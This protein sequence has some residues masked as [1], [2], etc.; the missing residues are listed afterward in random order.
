[1]R[2]F[3][4]FY[5]SSV[6]KKLIVG[7]TGL[8]LISYL[9]IH[10]FGNL[11]IFRADGGEAFDTYAEVLPQI[12]VIRI[13]EIG[14]FLLFI[15]HIIT[16]AY[17]WI[18]NKAARGDAYKIQKK[19]ETSKVTSR[20]MFLT[21]SIVFIFLVVH[22]R[23]FWFNSRYEATEGY[24][25]FE[26][27]RATFSNPV[28]GAFYIVAMFLLGFH[29]KHGFQSACQTFGIRT[30]NYVSFIDLIGIVVW[31]L[32]PLGFASMPLYFLLYF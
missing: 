27:V 3:I 20:T 11:L 18:L 10:L 1:M 31:L 13:I 5:N 32:I 4:D 29:L 26:V 14:L 30:K 15:L 2:A 7:L 9:V 6:G 25:M 21:G 24:S 28:Y 12:V 22:M 17:T 16:A 19:N 8:L 23:Q